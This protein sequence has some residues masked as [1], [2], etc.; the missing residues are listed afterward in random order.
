MTEPDFKEL[1]EKF[2]NAVKENPY[3]RGHTNYNYL[4]K[5]YERATRPQMVSIYYHS[6]ETVAYDNRDYALVGEYWY[7]IRG[8]KLY[9]V[10]DAS[11]VN[12]LCL[13]HIDSLAH[14]GRE[15]SND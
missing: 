4:L 7:R 13:A 15:H 8:D 11:F 5:E 2:Y 12:E 1:A 10:E 3:L 9:L 14:I 6:Y